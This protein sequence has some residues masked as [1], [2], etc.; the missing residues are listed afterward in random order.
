MYFKHDM[1]V[2]GRITD[3]LSF[4]NHFYLVTEVYI[5]Y[6]FNRHYHAYEVAPSS[7]MQICTVESLQD[8]HPLWIYQSYDQHLL[9][10]FFIPL[11]YY[12]LSDMD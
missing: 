11:K 10:T 1:P 9:D 2:F 12:V 7:T 6:T 4:Q 5:T 3:I 8:Y